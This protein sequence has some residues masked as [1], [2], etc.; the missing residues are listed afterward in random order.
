VNF[1]LGCKGKGN[2]FP[3]H[4]L[5]ANGGIAEMNFLPM[6]MMLGKTAHAVETL[7]FIASNRFF[8]A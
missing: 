2:A 3:R 1:F 5:S 7:H 8:I 6:Q 4:R